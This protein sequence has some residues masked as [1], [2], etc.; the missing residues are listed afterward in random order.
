MLYAWMDSGQIENASFKLRHQ[1]H[2]KR[3]IKVQSV[4]DLIE[5][6]IV[7]LGSPG[8]APDTGSLI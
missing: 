6:H 7:S 4:R 8:D 3:L 1:R 2:G 5:K